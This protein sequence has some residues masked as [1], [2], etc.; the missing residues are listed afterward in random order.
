MNTTA[1][2]VRLIAKG[3]R[4]HAIMWHVAEGWSRAFGPRATITDV[5][6]RWQIEPSTCEQLLGELTDRRVL[7]AHPEGVYELARPE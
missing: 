5:A 2:V 6:R 1:P 3:D 7:T 4:R